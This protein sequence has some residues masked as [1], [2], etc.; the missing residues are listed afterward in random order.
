MPSKP[1]K[2]VEYFTPSSAVV[3]KA[4]KAFEKPDMDYIEMT[5][6]LAGN[7]KL[8]A[9][10]Q[11]QASR[12]YDKFVGQ[13]ARTEMEE[14]LKNCDAKYRIARKQDRQFRE[15]STQVT[16]TLSHVASSQFYKSCRI[17]SSALC[18]MIF[19]KM[20][21]LPARYEPIQNSMDYSDAEGERVAN[22]QNLYLNYV[23]QKGKYTD[24]LKDSIK[25]LT[26]NANE[27]FSVEWEYCID[28]R[29][30]RVPGYYDKNGKAH[31][32]DPGKPPAI[33][34]D[35]EGNEI[36]SIVR[37]SGEPSNYVLVEKTRVVKN[38]PIIE[39]HDFKNSFMDMDIDDICKQS[40][41]IFYSQKPYSY[42]LGKAQSG[43]FMNVDK[44][45]NKH[46]FTSDDS[47]TDVINNDR[48]NNADY[49]LDRNP[50]GLYDTYHVWMKS[51]IDYKKKQWD[52]DQIPEIYEAVFVGKLREVDSSG[53]VVQKKSDV[54]E[55]AAAVCLQ[56]RKNPY[57]HK[58][59]PYH[60]AHSHPDQRGL[61]HMGLYSLLECNI[62]EQTATRN[63][64][65]DN[66]KL[67]VKAPF[68]AER[69]A[70]L[71]RDC[72]FHNG[73]Q[74]VWVKEGTFNNSIEKMQIPDMTH[75]AIPMTELLQREADEVAGT[76]DAVK[77]EYAGSRTTGTEILTANKQAMKPLIEDARYIAN[78]Y[79]TP[80]LEDVKEL[81]RQFADPEQVL[82]VTDGQGGVLGEINPGELYGELETK[83]TAIDKF[84]SDL[85]AQQILV[86]FIQAGGYD[87]SVA[88]MGKTGAV[89][90]WRLFADA[91]NLPDSYKIYPSGQRMVEAENQAIADINAIKLDPVDAL[92]NPALLPKEGESHDVHIQIL[93]AYQ[94]KVE[95]LLSDPQI[96]EATRLYLQQQVTALRLYIAIHEQLKVQEEAAIS[97]SSNVPP[98]Q[99]GGAM[100]QAGAAGQVPVQ[101][102][103]EAGDVLSGVQ[104]QM[105]G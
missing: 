25:L 45:T 57:N 21:E 88:F 33:M 49:K 46:L 13:A 19:G 89:Y 99:T 58:R 29:I 31:E 40:C 103:E 11:T 97:Q 35:K 14:Y 64:A 65:H 32:Y 59:Y 96:D 100:N 78:Q 6:N 94:D 81:G 41:L 23:W 63:Q 18:D 83:I 42:F 68:K 2:E 55:T 105:V 92:Q 85:Q 44:I 71:S 75:I 34:Y 20:D 4:I 93:Q 36:V 76:L 7:G 27:L 69:G 38:Q 53:K 1:E 9:K 5:D 12:Y 26:K 66:F 102:G 70:L 90:F 3:D 54:K 22:G 28:K 24:T 51:P 77:G 72:T 15:D 82:V 8:V 39:R 16:N 56:L 74:I 60:V 10:F 79:L 104:G 50:N 91:M 87:K 98:Q 80:L 37:D 47:S 17:I 62:E 86:N 95:I 101:P 43:D 30:E 52:T 73:N 84:E 61:W 48:D 67:A